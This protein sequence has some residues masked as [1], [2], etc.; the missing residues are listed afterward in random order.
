MSAMRNRISSVALVAAVVVVAG[1]AV[2]LNQVTAQAATATAPV[3]VTVNARAGLATMPA[4]GL[5][6]NDAVWD[7]QLGTTAVSDLLGAAGVGMLRYPGGS[8]GDIYHWQ[9]N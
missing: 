5:G 3:T 8:Y 9:T 4:T 2:A 7:G 6:V 1:G